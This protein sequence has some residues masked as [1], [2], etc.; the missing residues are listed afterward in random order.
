M[1]PTNYIYIID[2]IIAGLYLLYIIGYYYNLHIAGHNGHNAHCM[3]GLSGMESKWPYA[4]QLRK[5]IT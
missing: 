1:C 5:N 4:T 2:M 3:K